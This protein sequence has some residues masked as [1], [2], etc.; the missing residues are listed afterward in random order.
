[1]PTGWVPLAVVGI[2]LLAAGGAALS[3]AAT[4]LRPRTLGLLLGLAFVLFGVAGLLRAPAG[5][6]AVAVGYSLYRLVEVVAGARL[7][8]RIDSA[9]RATV[10][11]I[12][13]LGTDVSAIVLYALWPLG[14]LVLIAVLGL[15]LAAALPRWL[16]ERK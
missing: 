15:A 1:V 12:A 8:D 4:R 7:Q 5:L 3:G 9:R 2:P 14:Q 13:G 16:R 6:A 10:T 11:S